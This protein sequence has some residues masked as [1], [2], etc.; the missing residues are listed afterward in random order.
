MNVKDVD[1][2]GNPSSKSP[3]SAPSVRATSGRNRGLETPKKPCNKCR[4]LTRNALCAE[5]AAKEDARRR[6]ARAYH[7]K[8]RPGPRQR[9]YDT[10]W[11]KI[12]RMYLRRHPL[13][14]RCVGLTPATMVHHIKPVAKYPELRL[15]P[16]NFMALCRDCHEIEEG[17]K[18]WPTQR[19]PRH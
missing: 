12:R 4:K 17:R 6:E 11:E 8:Y 10:T 13:C 18:K 5:C 19:S 9:G 14:E 15:D 2:G 7:D 3:K 16:D 1:M